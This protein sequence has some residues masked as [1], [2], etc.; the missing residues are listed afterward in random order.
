MFPRIVALF[1]YFLPEVFLLLAFCLFADAINAFLAQS[2]GINNPAF[3]IL[4]AFFIFIKLFRDGF[5]LNK[6]DKE[7]K[8]KGKIGIASLF[9]IFFVAIGLSSEFYSIAISK[10]IVYLNK[11]V[12]SLF[13]GISCLA[14]SWLIADMFF[15]VK[16]KFF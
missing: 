11:H 4:F 10:D 12:S 15:C 1:L 5:F 16:H 14:G 13:Q 2:S 7:D 9:I 3:L 6:K 8:P